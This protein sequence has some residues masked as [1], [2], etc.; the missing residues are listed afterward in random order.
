MLSAP[1]R[2]PRK[3]PRKRKTVNVARP[4]SSPRRKNGFF[5]QLKQ[6]F[7]RTW[8]RWW[9]HHGQPRRLFKYAFLGLFWMSILLLIV[10]L[11][12]FANL[13]NIDQVVDMDSSPTVIILDKDDHEVARLGDTQGQIMPVKQ[14]SPYMVQAVLAIEDRRFYTHFGIDPLGMARAMWVNATSS[15]NMQGGSTITQQLAKNLFL[16]PERTLTRKV[17]E[18][19]LAFYLEYKYSKDQILA[20]YLNRVYFGGGAYGV[21]AASR[22]YF[23]KSAKD[24][25]IDEAALL[26]GLLKAPSRYS[27]DS[28]P[29]LAAKRA[30]TVI[31]AMA[32]AGY[33]TKAKANSIKVNP[34]PKKDYSAAGSMDMRY[35]TDWIMTQSSGF[36]GDEAQNM[37]IRTTLDT[38]LQKFAAKHLRDIIEKDGKALKISQGALVSMKMDGSILAMVGGTDYRETQFNRA[39]QARRQPGSAFKPFVYLAAMESGRYT[40]DSWI[41]DTPIQVGGYH[42]TNYDGKY[43]GGMSVQTALAHSINTVAV[44]LLHETG[45]G[46]T[47][48]VAQRLG[49]TDPLNGDLSLAL[50]TSGV[51]LISLTSAYATFGNHGRAVE[52]FGIRDIRDMK[53]KVLYKNPAYDPAPLVDEPYVSMMNQMMQGVVQYGTGTRARLDRAVAGKTGTSQ[54]Y[55]DALFVGYT[56]DIATGVWVGNDNNAAMAKVTGGATPAQI[57]HDVMQYASRDLAPRDFSGGFNDGL[58]PS[59]DP[60]V[61]PENNGGGE[62]G[63]GFNDML[64]NLFG[65]DGQFKPDNTEYLN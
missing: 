25:N 42:P 7:K 49:I 6:D 36:I 27:P 45:I 30:R 24:L 65:G 51:R 48:R 2:P 34:L 16:S 26:A 32:D 18:A 39:T 55:R 13:P 22:I 53:G 1:P 56:A 28:D 19:A 35:F 61:A 47:K 21:D 12:I 17:K 4:A 11:Y 60:L 44:R 3:S 62:S 41:E 52:P 54:N 59:R 8:K 50:G 9:G 57:W 5:K 37:T 10:S 43:R 64:N 38:D 23:N 15:G 46:P 14:M 20:A 31:Y 63:G 58:P 29:Q 33:I 40:P